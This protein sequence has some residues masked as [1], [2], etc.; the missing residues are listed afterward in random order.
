MYQKVTQYPNEF[1]T[2]GDLICHGVQVFD[3]SWS[4]YVPEHKDQLIQKII[5]R[6]Y[7]EEIGVD[8]PDRF[9]FYINAHLRNIM[10][11]YN[12]LY[13]SE[14]IKI[15]P[16]LNH[17]I[18]ASTR[19]IENLLKR[20][21]S[22]NDKMAKAI[23]D[24]AGVT[25]GIRNADKSGE[26]DNTVTTNGNTTETGDVTTTGKEHGEKNTGEDFKENTTTTENGTKTTEGTEHTAGT[27][28]GKTDEHSTVERNLEGEK[29]ETPK[30]TTIKD[31]QYG[32]TEGT[33]KE[34]TGSS[35]KNG[36]ST[37][38]WTEGTTDHAT[39]V[40]NTTLNETTAGGSQKDYADTPQ[41]KLNPE[42]IRKDY[43]T[44]VTWTDDTSTHDS[45]TN[46]DQTYDDKLD[47][48]HTGEGTN[49][50][51]GETSEK[52]EGSLIKTGNDTETTTHSGEDV[53]STEELET[54]AKDSVTNSTE[55]VNKDVTTDETVT[56][57]NTTTQDKKGESDKVEVED[58]EN[59][60]IKNT[61]MNTN[62]NEEE[63]TKGVSSSKETDT[64]NQR[65]REKRNTSELTTTT[66]KDDTTQ[67]TDMGETSITSGFMNVSASA[68]LEAF[69]KTFLNIDNM[70]V[71]ELATNFMLTM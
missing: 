23:R 43:L 42:A 36:G 60:V 8:T 56:T 47:K 2:L 66:E 32:S 13:A 58:V 12:Q 54:T 33:Q 44:N 40:T 64:S 61:N 25:S 22:T 41:K 37:D 10:P 26:V 3:D 17:S 28:T 48:T 24:F 62:D 21:N 30:T 67:T 55:T 31:M 50:E 38:T 15:N 11:Y 19:S 51:T 6:Y 53:T 68:L 9:V 7:F 45:T 70:I 27:T 18:N 4:T 29:I 20:V 59:K 39:T 57:N 14:L 71:E 46:Q 1:P 5:D 69:R 63:V 49:T 34:T 16:L 52:V 35:S 65:T